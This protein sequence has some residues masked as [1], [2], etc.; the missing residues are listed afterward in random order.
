MSTTTTT[1]PSKKEVAGPLPTPIPANRVRLPSINELTS[2]SNK[3][4]P[5]LKEEGASSRVLPSLNPSASNST[6]VSPTTAPQPYSSTGTGSPKDTNH[7]KYPIKPAAASNYVLGNTAINANAQKLPSPTI[8]YYEQGSNQSQPTPQTQHQPAPGAHAPVQYYTYHQSSIHLP[9]LP[10]HQQVPQQ[11]SYSSPNT[12]YQP[13]Y[14]QQGQ[15]QPHHIPYQ[16][17]HL[18]N[19]GMPGAAASTQYSLPE[20]IN[21]PSNKCHRCGTTETPEWRRG[22]N[23]VRTLCNACG[24]FHAKLVKRKGAALAAEEVLNNKVC[25]GKNGRRISIKKQL[26]NENNLLKHEAM[27]SEVYNQQQQQQSH[28][29]PPQHPQP[30]PQILPPP[31]HGH[32]HPH[33]PLSSSNLP[34]PPPIM[35]HNYAAM[36]LL[37]HWLRNGINIKVMTIK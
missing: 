24:L 30:A 27:T 14:Y 22:P 15:Q 23:G 35:N 26:L 21:K 32:A 3:H 29:T 2:N 13:Y 19:S 36:P 20:V 25:K 12:Y 37:R 31:G 34:L 4:L 6:G 11:I 18:Y 10:Q 28:P 5:S 9:P 1:S 33:F 17:P 16:A 7:F 8:P